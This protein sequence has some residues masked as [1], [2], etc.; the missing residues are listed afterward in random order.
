MNILAGLLFLLCTAG[1]LYIFGLIK[2]KK[3]EKKSNDL[4]EVQQKLFIAEKKAEIENEAI[5]SD[6]IDLVN[7]NNK[8]FGGNSK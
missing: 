3:V 7:A 4:E 1:G 6:I 2:G 8:R 5:N